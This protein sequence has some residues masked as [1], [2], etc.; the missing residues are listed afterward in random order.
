MVACWSWNRALDV[1]CG[2]NEWAKEMRSR[3]PGREVT[4]V[5][6]ACPGADRLVDVTQGLPYPDKHFDV[7]TAFDM[8]E[9]LREADVPFVLAEF[10]RVSRFFVFTIAYRPSLNTWQGE[11]LHP[12]VRPPEWWREQ[13]LAQGAY[14]TP[15]PDGF[16]VGGWEQEATETPAER[17][18]ADL[19]KT[20]CLVG[21]GPSL[22]QVKG[23][24]VDAHDVVVRLNN[25]VTRTFE[26][27]AG[28]KTT[29]W[30][31]AGNGMRPEGGS[32]L[33]LCVHG[34]PDA[35]LPYTWSIPRTFYTALR[36]ELQAITGNP[37]TVPSCG[38]VVARYLLDN[39]VVESLTLAGF[40]H[41]SRVNTGRHHYWQDRN[42]KAP[43]DH[44]GE[45]ERQI[46]QQL[47]SD[48]I[49]YLTNHADS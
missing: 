21:N 4:G 15:G 26:H 6:F 1:G 3:H 45:A 17:P 43:A 31:W 47:H 10:A 38:Y 25:Y 5:D 2:W 13:L 39:G 35:E 24:D 32:P 12:T 42:L 48:R 33:G 22:L 36:D 46:L 28:R 44:D 29:L 20:W 7:L 40:D 37:I 8:L 11:N 16:W 27:C 41:F 34:T 23:A 49:I 30:G 9:H 19:G 14:L 18:L